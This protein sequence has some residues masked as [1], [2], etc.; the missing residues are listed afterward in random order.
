MCQIILRKPHFEIPYE[1][2]ESAILT[3][4]DGS[5]YSFDD[6]SG[7][8]TT[9]KSVTQP[10]PA[11]LYRTINEDL[12]DS[13]I[14]L[15]LRFNTAG[16]TNWRNAHPFSVLEQKTDG[17]DLR[18]AHN[19]TIHSYKTKAVGTESDT[20][21]FVKFFVRPL[22]KRLIKGNDIDNILTDPF[23]GELLKDKI[24]AGSVLTFL[25]GM[26]NSLIINE[27]GNG[28]KQEEEWYYSN[29]YSFN[30]THRDPKPYQHTNL[31]FK[32]RQYGGYGSPLIDDEAD[33]WG[34]MGGYSSPV[35][36]YQSNVSPLYSTEITEKDSQVLEFTAAYGVTIE[37]ILSMS[38]G[39]ISAIVTE[40]PAEATS[41]VKELLYN[42]TELK[43]ERDK[44][45]GQVRFF[46]VSK[47]K[48]VG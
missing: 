11:A 6:G 47:E 22:F 24:P 44:L 46:N 15:H 34:V 16:D 19:G 35:K 9:I 23:V 18:M 29:T 3:N 5:G 41:L 32:G 13:S 37:Q 33:I 10:D 48:K 39:T 36:S 26:G 27:T 7:K 42:I 25:D 2:F 30:K 31:G 8:L 17:I 12:I 4:P 21:S 45:E 14:L 1:K 38:D 20:R 40:E 43:K 28:G